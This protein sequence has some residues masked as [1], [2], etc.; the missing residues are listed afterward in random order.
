[1]AASGERVE[2]SVEAEADTR[3]NKCINCIIDRKHDSL[4][5]TQLPRL[6]H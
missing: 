4:S 6:Q 5:N 2:A 3:E 1:M